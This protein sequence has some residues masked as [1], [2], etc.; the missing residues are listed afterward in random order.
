MI[1]RDTRIWNIVAE[2]NVADCLNLVKG[3]DFERLQLSSQ[4]ED[5]ILNISC[6][7]H[8]DPKVLLYVTLSSIGHFA[9]SVNVYNMETKQV[10]PICVYQ[11]LIAPSGQYSTNQLEIL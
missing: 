3:C 5:F 11:I 6:N 8:C 7:H 4:I 10:K 1:S 9:E 2:K